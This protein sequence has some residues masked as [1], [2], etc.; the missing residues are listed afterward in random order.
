[1]ALL[2]GDSVVDIIKRVV[3]GTVLE[4]NVESLAL[5]SREV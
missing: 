4:G 1:M 3:H 5:K 2:G